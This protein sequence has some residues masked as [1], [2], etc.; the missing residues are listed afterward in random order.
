MAKIK[1][2]SLIEDNVP[3]HCA[4]TTRQC[5]KEQGVNL[6]DGWPGNNPNLNP[7]ELLWCQTKQLQNKDCATL[8]AEPK[9]CFKNLGKILPIYL[10]KLSKAYEGG[11]YGQEGD[12][13]KCIQELYYSLFI[14]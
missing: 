2:S 4:I 3:V 13:L 9:K 11:C 10:Q 14:K 12:T 1:C 7:I 8:A 5:Y 6:S